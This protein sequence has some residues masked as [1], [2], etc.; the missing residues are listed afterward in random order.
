MF[1]LS[2]YLKFAKGQ[3][4]KSVSS[5]ML[6]HVLNMVLFSPDLKAEKWG[7]GSPDSPLCPTS[8]FHT[9]I[10]ITAQTLQATKCTGHQPEVK[11]QQ[12]PEHPLQT[13]NVRVQGQLSTLPQP[14]PQLRGDT[15]MSKLST[16]SWAKKP[17]N[18]VFT[19][20]M[21]TDTS[22]HIPVQLA[23]QPIHG[24]KDQRPRDSRKAPG[25]L[26]GD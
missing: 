8:P 24:R 11:N 17:K 16:R 13:G 10:S 18:S 9:C 14:Y 3:N 23:A 22:I 2:F 21:E 12:L 1:H 26:G 15:C 4:S 19:W 7:R 5:Q 20:R 6:H 25:R